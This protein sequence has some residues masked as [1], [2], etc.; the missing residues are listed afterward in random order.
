METTIEPTV[1]LSLTVKDSAS[2][3]AFYQKAFGAEELFRMP[4][5]DGGIAHAEFMIGN[6]RIYMSDEAAA[7]HAFAMPEGVTASCLFSIVTDNCDQSY[8][9]AIEAGASSL[10]EPADQFWGGRSA[11][12]R[13]PFGYRWSFVQKIEE[14]S[15]EELGKRAKAF[16]SSEAG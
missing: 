1:S 6:T 4:S 7:W 9:R 10:S 15:P 8:E 12:L 5:P 11:L 16:F 2:A 13:D 14:V 3:L